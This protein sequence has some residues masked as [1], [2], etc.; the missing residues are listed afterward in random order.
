MLASGG[1]QRGI[2]LG[3]AVPALVA[4][5]RIIAASDGGDSDSAVPGDVPL[6]LLQIAGSG[7]R[8]R[9]AAVEKGMHRDR[10]A[11]IAHD[12][13]EGSDLVLVRMDPA[14]RNKPHDMRRAAA[15]FKLGDKLLQRRQAC[16]LAFGEHLVDAREILDDDPAGT[17][18]GV[19]D[20]GIAHLPVGQT[21][22]MLA[23]V[24]LGMRPAPHQLV[25]DRGFR[26]IDRVVG[27]VRPLAPAVED[28]EH[29]RFRARGHG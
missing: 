7:L 2:G 14:R 18:I 8:R 22:V 20:L 29:Q 13:G 5:H 15:L 16:D 10:Y 3:D 19:A 6:K 21:N 11:G 28:A 27:A 26:L 9:V 25:P 17:D 23:R 1:G 4:V 24:E 12:G